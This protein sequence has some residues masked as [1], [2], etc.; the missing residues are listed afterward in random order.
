M[1]YYGGEPNEPTGEKVD[2]YAKLSNNWIY[3]VIATIVVVLLILYWIN[4]KYMN[5][6]PQALRG[7]Y[8]SGASLRQ[9]SEDSSSNRG[10]NDLADNSRA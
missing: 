9:Y 1:E 7:V 4:E 8:T 2:I 5:I 6:Q 10:Q 3:I